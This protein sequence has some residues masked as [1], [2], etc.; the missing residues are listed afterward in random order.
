[1]RPGPGGPTPFRPSLLPVLLRRAREGPALLLTGPPGSGKTTLLLAVAEALRDEGVQPVYLDL[2]G[3]VSTPERFVAAALACLPAEAFGAHLP[4]A[5]EVRRLA[6]AGRVLAGRAAVAVFGLWRALLEARAGAVSLLL[7]DATEIRSLAYFEGLR[8]VERPFLA[9]LGERPLGV[10]LA[11]SYPAQARRFWPDLPVVELSPLSAEEIAALGIAARADPAALARASFGWP[12]YLDLLAR[13]LA[14][15]VS[16]EEAWVE[17]M[18]PGGRL[19]SACRHTYETL[20]LRSRG[21]GVSKAALAT[22]AEHDGENLTA[23]VRRLGRTPGAVRDY[24]GWLLG[25]DAL[26][27]SGKRYFYVDGLLAL[28]VRLYTRGQPPSPEELARAA[29]A[30]IG[31]E[32]PPRAK[33]AAERESLMEID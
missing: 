14:D 31:A 20:L 12:R 8:Q 9:A 32:P 28:W 21:Y 16:L 5:T 10:L 22:V 26:R 7:D 25:V 19:E 24:L 13:R 6:Q 1:M 2:M 15:G 17:E 4:Q 3:A 27:M 23:L 33:P 29:R 11:T 30:L 18:A